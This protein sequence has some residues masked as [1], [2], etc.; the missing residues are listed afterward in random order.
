MKR[1][2]TEAE[3]RQEF[4]EIYAIQSVITNFLKKVGSSN[5]S[6]IFNHVHTVEVGESSKEQVVEIVIKALGNMLTDGEICSEGNPIFDMVTDYKWTLPVS[7]DEV[8][9]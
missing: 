5:L 4:I 1:R 8:I 6:Q 2:K 3:L 7:E 9:S